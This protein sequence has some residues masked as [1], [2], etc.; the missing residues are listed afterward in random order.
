MHVSSFEWENFYWSKREKA[1]HLTW[2][3]RRCLRTRTFFPDPTNYCKKQQTCP[4]RSFVLFSFRS[5]VSCSPST[6]SHI[7]YGLFLPVTRKRESW[8]TSEEKRMPVSSMRQQNCSILQQTTETWQE[9]AAAEGGKRAATELLH[10]CT[11][12]VTNYGR[13]IFAGS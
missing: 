7:R 8:F 12:H 6:H 9:Q 4:V 10:N 3:R 1:F 5:R 2:K 13:A 11:K